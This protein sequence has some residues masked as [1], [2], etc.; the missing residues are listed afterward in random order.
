MAALF[1]ATYPE[2]T[3]ALVLFHPDVLGPGTADR[4]TQEELSRLREEW[5]TQEFADELL[6]LGTPSISANEEDRRWFANWLRVGASPSV[7]HALNRAYFETDLRDVLP[8]VRVPT[9]V[10]YRPVWEGR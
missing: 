3:R 9:L 7:A 8:A 1:A 2:R 6:A 4:E 5:G 10:L